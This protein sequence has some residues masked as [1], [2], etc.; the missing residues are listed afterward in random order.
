VRVPRFARTRRGQVGLVIL[1]T[2]VLIALVGPLFAPH[3]PAAI[4]GAPGAGPSSSDLL[5]TDYLGHDV[6][7]RVLWGGR[8]V[9]W[10]SLAA[11]AIAYLVGMTIGLIAGYNRSILD[12]LL[13]R[14]VDV[15][16]VF[17]PLLF[18]LIVA[19]SVGTSKLVL[20]VGVALVQIPGVA[21]IVY[22]ATREVSVRLYV[23]AAVARGERTTAVILREILPNIL[24]PVIANLGLAITF[25]ILLIAAVNFLGL[26][27]Q[28]PAA[29]WALM[30][31]E[32]R[33]ILSLNPWSTIA[34][35]ALIAMLTIG[36]NLVGDAIAQGLGS[37]EQLQVEAIGGELTI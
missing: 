7:S 6:L 12:P 19:T 26:G 3:P 18:F 23:E 31:S 17:P 34:P 11:T 4:V 2:V 10:L 24:G 22:T 15:I 9:L 27:L 20:I 21:R 25:S 35:A 13:M 30:I 16:L 14:S 1:A 5:G 33:P 28:P 37:S 29:N 32:N 8:S 36:V